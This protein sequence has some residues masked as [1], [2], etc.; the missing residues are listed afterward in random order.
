ML[1]TLSGWFLGLALFAGPHAVD[2]PKTEKAILVEIQIVQEC[3]GLDCPPPP[4]P[5]PFDAQLC[6]RVNDNYYLGAYRLW[7]FPWAPPGKKLLATKGQTVEIVI[8]KER[9]LMKAPFHIKLTRISNH[10]GSCT[11]G[12]SS[13]LNPNSFQDRK[14]PSVQLRHPAFS[15]PPPL[16]T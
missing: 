2:P 6:F 14:D 10:Q 9:V 5:V 1:M 3:T 13:P 8:E 16:S 11:P 4:F 15:I 12:E 7:G